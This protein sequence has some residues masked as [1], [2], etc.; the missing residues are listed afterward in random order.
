LTAR[1]DIVI[2]QRLAEPEFR[3]ENVVGWAPLQPLKQGFVGA[4]ELSFLDECLCLPE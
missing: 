3:K 4:F 2:K 1:Q